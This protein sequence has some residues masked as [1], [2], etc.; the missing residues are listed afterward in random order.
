MEAGTRTMSIAAFVARHHQALRDL[1]ARAS[2]SITIDQLERQVTGAK[3]ELLQTFASKD[4][5]RQLQGAQEALSD[6]LAAVQGMVAAKAD[7]SD[8]LRLGA[9]A[10]ELMA[11]SDWKADAA[12]QLAE[13][14]ASSLEARSGVD[15]AVDSLGRLSGVIQTLSAAVGARAVISDVRDIAAR[16]DQLHAAFESERDS[17]Q[18]SA[19]AVASRLEGMEGKQHALSAHFD[20]FDRDA[21]AL[22]SAVTE[23]RSELSFLRSAVDSRAPAASLAAADNELRALRAGIG[24]LARKVDVSLRF[25]QWYSEQSSVYEPNT[26]FLERTLGGARPVSAAGGGTGGGAGGAS[27]IPVPVAQSLFG[28]DSSAVA[29]LHSVG[30]AGQLP[31]EPPLPRPS[32]ASGI[33]APQPVRQA[34]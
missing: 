26:D 4:G 31:H 32:S 3:S 9:A 34:S 23:L 7:R 19:V 22:R 12:K 30:S 6:A 24:E 14:R 2:R 5:L 33:P 1:E 20:I 16:V 11:F 10:T 27:R 28:L 8:I 25:I 18:R 17:N 15:K 21:A 13:L 29:G